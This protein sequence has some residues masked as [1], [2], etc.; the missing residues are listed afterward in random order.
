MPDF[1]IL[2]RWL[3]QYPWTIGFALAFVILAVLELRFA[4][5]APT[6]REG[7]MVL[8]FG[9]GLIAGAFALALPIGAVASAVF[10]QDRHIGLFQLW[11]APLAVQFLI[12]LLARSLVTYGVHRLAHRWAPL[13]ALHRVHHQDEAVDLSTALRNHPLEL[14]A[15]LLPVCAA[16]LALGLAPAVAAGVELAILV[17]NLFAHSDIALPERFDRLARR[18]LVTPSFHLVHHRP[19]RARHDGNY[20]EL[21]TLWDRMFGTQRHDEGPDRLGLEQTRPRDHRLDGALLSP[22]RRSD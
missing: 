11:A 6:V 5:R 22:L 2:S 12:G 20:G 13:W 16:T 1:E 10:A 8:N 3:A 15:I 19:D 7:R 17:A 14:L 4:A 18:V 21:F 9:L